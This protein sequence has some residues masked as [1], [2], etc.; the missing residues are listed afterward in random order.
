MYGNAYASEFK[1]SG[2]HQAIFKAYFPTPLPSK[3]MD[4]FYGK[5][6]EGSFPASLAKEEDGWYIYLDKFRDLPQDDINSILNF[7][8]NEYEKYFPDAIPSHF[9]KIENKFIKRG[10][11]SMANQFFNKVWEIPSTIIFPLSFI[12]FQHMTFSLLYHENFGESI[13]KAIMDLMERS[14]YPI[15]IS[16]KEVDDN[17]PLGYRNFLNWNRQNLSNFR[18]VENR[19]PIDRTINEELGIFQSKM[20]FLIKS[21]THYHSKESMDSVLII[22]NLDENLRGNFSRVITLSENFNLFQIHF[23]SPLTSDLMANVI[24]PIGSGNLHWGYYRNNTINNYFIVESRNTRHL[25][26]GFNKH[27]SEVHKSG[28]FGTLYYLDYLDRFWGEL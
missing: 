19:V 24:F 9:L 4:V 18:I 11:S 1:N 21:M 22:K 8:S 7:I 28:S 3:Y 25:L 14:P 27:L 13:S 12:S 23:K 6:L 15:E 20:I 10:M 26:K 16:I 5:N 2:L 17:D